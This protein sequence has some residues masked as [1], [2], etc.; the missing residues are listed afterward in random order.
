MDEFFYEWDTNK[1]QSNIEKHGIDFETASFIFE[2]QTTRQV[3]DRFDY[4]E[5]R[6][7]SF[8]AVDDRVLAVIWTSRGENVRRI[9]SARQAGR[10][11]RRE[12]HAATGRSG[13]DP[14][15]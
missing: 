10:D 4:G 15:D 14:E 12:Y 8:G 2:R 5:V 7:R 3:D 11:E 9:I 13:S 1:E 6:Y